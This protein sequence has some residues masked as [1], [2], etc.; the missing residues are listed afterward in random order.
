MPAF[1]FLRPTRLAVSC[2]AAL[3]ALVAGG[4]ARAVDDG[5]NVDPVTLKADRLRSVPD[6]ESLAEGDV[7]LSR[8]DLRIRAD[9]LRYLAP[10]DRAA[11]EGRVRVERDGIEL[12]TSAAELDLARWE[13]WLQAAEFEVLRLGTRGQASRIDLLGRDRMRAADARYTSCPRT[14]G[15]ADP[16]WVLE[17]REVTLDFGANEGRARQARL[18]FLGTTILALPT[19][20][21]PVTDARKSG[22]LPP[23]LNLDSRSGLELSIPRYW[24]LAPNLDL[25]VAPRLM[26][27]RGAGVE[28]EFRYLLPNAQ[29]RAELNWL[30]HDR[31]R[32]RA[33][34]ALD[35]QHRQTLPWQVD[36]GLEAIRVSDDAWWKDFPRGTASLTP[37]LLPFSVRAERSFEAIGLD[38][39]AYLRAQGWQVLGDEA[40]P[41]VAPYARGPQLGVTAH[42]LRGPLEFSGLGELNRFTLLNRE[43][44]DL[45]PD[46]WRLHAAGSLAW[47]WR[48]AGGWL[49]PKL[50]LQATRYLTD[51][52]MADGARQ[53]E[54]VLPTV[55]V[56]AGLNF[57]RDT[58]ALFGRSLRQTLEP[59]LVYVRT[60]Y[61]RQDQLPVFDAFGKEFNFSSIFAES[62]FSGVDRVSDDHQ[63]TAGLTSRLLDPATGGEILRLGLAQRYLLRDLQVAPALDGAPD[64]APLSQ[65]F[66]DLLLLGSTTVVPDWAFDA[67]LQH[68]PDNGRLRRAVLG[69]TFSPAPFK[70]LN[71]RY[72]LAR[73]LSE[74]V[75]AGWQW[76]VYRGAGPSGSGC[77]GTVY[78]VGRVNYSV[79]DSRVTDSL[80]GIEVDTVCWIGRVV[81]ER[82]ST[83]RSEATTRL[84]VQLELVG[85]SR[86]GSNPLKVLKDNIP[87]YR[88]L[89]EER[90]ASPAPGS[91]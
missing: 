54:R 70:T 79:R 14:D 89:R 69:A 30:P 36:F 57:E 64:G 23:S 83:G 9:R 12:R 80:V 58:E 43:P 85:L 65:R 33:R 1:P 34:H 60:P 4:A 21:F 31:V 86:L 38:G 41:I 13:G 90:G 84:M 42:R 71:L 26:T 55:S 76:P 35:L 53:A 87:G 44:G 29:G 17:A 49:V 47:P 20:S 18:R 77:R 68:S 37:R 7:E 66:S 56:D 10:Q 46:G 67:A 63:L 11:A 50:T 72:R 25:T 22:W 59:R 16:D 78:G 74:Q 62:A 45:R 19:L 32:N 88:L 6:G 82:L 24:N 51:R 61:E 5:G 91:P 81:A 75:E 8:G 73:G 15:D 2:A 40:E 27:R 39:Q 3:G 28:G 52:P 48:P